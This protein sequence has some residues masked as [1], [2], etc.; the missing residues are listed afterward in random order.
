LSSRFIHRLGCQ[1][2]ERP[3][4]SSGRW[5]SLALDHPEGLLSQ[6]VRRNAS[7]RIAARLIECAGLPPSPS[8]FRHGAM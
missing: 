1:K 4:N 7:R 3:S 2:Q 5:L 8:I 6:Q